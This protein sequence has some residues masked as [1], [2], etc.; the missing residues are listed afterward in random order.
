MIHF[1]CGELIVIFF[2]F[3]KHFSNGTATTNKLDDGTLVA[4][5]SGF[6]YRYSKRF[7]TTDSIT[8]K[9]F[10]GLKVP[11]LEPQTNLMTVANTVLNTSKFAKMVHPGFLVKIVIG[12]LSLRL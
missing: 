3:N 10:S 6:K 4:H 7:E 1:L 5:F 2:K 12:I 11:V 9:H 8:V